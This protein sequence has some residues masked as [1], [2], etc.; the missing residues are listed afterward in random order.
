VPVLV[1]NAGSSSLKLRV[2]DGDDV[3]LA[4]DVGPG[5]VDAIRALCDRAG[6]IQ[7]VGHRVVHGGARFQ[8]PVV[9]DDDV[10]RALSALAPLAPLQQPAAIA[11]IR[12][13]RDALPGV[14]AVACFDTAFHATLPAAAFTY[15]LPPEWR[16]RYGLRRFGFHGLSHA[17]GSRR[18]V[19][20]AGTSARRIVT[21]HLGSGSSLAAVVDGACV[22][23]TMGFTPNEGIPMST[24]SGSVDVGMLIWLLQEGLDG[25]E[26]AD[27]LQHRS[28]LAGLA[29]TSDMRVVGARA[30]A[31]D[32]RAGLAVEVWLHHLVKAV[33]AMAAAAGGLDV[34]IFTGGIGERA[35]GLR[36]AA[37]DRLAWLGVHVDR[38]KNESAR[39]DAVISPAGAAVTVAV[40]E[41]RE[42]IEIARGARSAVAD[43]AS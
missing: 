16:D 22:D 42:D 5:D 11:G 17:Y 1:V 41:A 33:A 10:L 25:D 26:L 28:G 9:I 31:G 7:C 3:R 34:L 39:G 19:E 18:A 2:L 43:P 6:A 32:E 38:A 36:Q 15:A 23:T 20:L 8:M 14:A 40:I 4:D 13:A 24:R 30:A 12:A 29:G 35:G 21:C 27:G 37:A